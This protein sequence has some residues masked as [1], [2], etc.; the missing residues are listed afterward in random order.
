MNHKK[1]TEDVAHRYKSIFITFSPSIL[2]VGAVFVRIEEIGNGRQSNQ[3]RNK[4]AK[5][6]RQLTLRMGNL[7][8]RVLWLLL[9]WYD[10]GYRRNLLPWN[11]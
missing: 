4:V 2:W 9:H 3:H 8:F 10:D 6:V 5:N 1:V 7:M 11:N